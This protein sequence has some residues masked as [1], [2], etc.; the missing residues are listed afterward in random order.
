MRFPVQGRFI[1]RLSMLLT[2]PKVNSG[3]QNRWMSYL[4][5]VDG[6]LA[7]KV[8]GALTTLHPL[9]LKIL[10]AASL[11]KQSTRLFKCLHTDIDTLA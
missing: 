6:S 10:N 1:D 3:I 2:A 11:N 5:Q 7:G 9:Y 8:G 4:Q